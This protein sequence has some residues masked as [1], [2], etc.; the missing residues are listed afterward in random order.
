MIRKTLCILIQTLAVILVQL[1]STKVIAETCSSLTMAG[2]PDFPP[3]VWSDYR[4]TRGAARDLLEQAL[5]KQGI[6]LKTDHVGGYRRV[7]KALTDGRIQLIT[8]IPKT[9]E[10]SAIATF[11]STPLY[12][13][14]LTVLTKRSHGKKPH[15][16][17]DLLEL[18][19]A[20]PDQLSVEE[21]F[22]NQQ[23]PKKLIRTFTPNLALKMLK[24][25]RVDYTIYP[26]I[27]DDLLVSLLNLEGTLEKLPLITQKVPVFVAFSKNIDCSISIQQLNT[28]LQKLTKSGEAEK[29]LNDSLYKWMSYQLKK[30]E[31]L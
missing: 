20:M 13:H 26:N 12:I 1:T 10:T 25:G 19:G 30:R 4:E 2:P 18:K 14:S 27:Q 8:G 9:P 22:H 5:N 15:N 3:V 16:W 7:L 21:I 11:S 17:N 24:I 29:I 23:K 28:D 6:E 31:S